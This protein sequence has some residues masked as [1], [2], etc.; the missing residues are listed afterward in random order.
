MA[1]SVASGGRHQ[2]QQDQLL[3]EGEA[4]K[5][6]EDAEVPVHEGLSPWGA[7]LGAQ[8]RNMEDRKNI[9]GN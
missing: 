9:T 8:R 6:T 5:P 1:V 2:R 3:G 7:S 4:R